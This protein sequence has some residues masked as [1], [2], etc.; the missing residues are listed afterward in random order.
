VGA[1]QSSQLA[2][3]AIGEL[4]KG[5]QGGVTASHREINNK[6]MVADKFVSQEV[7][8]RLM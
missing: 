6:K 7:T 2:T 5:K 3:I 4:I 8:I 1:V